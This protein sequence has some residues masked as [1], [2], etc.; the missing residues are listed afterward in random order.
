[1]T[2]KTLPGLPK[3]ELK[4]PPSAPSM[5]DQEPMAIIE[6]TLRASDFILADGAMLVIKP[7]VMAVYRHKSAK[8][9]QGNPV[10]SITGNF[11]VQLAVKGST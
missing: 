2:K 7:N 9:P 11:K 6:E 8:D 3:P 10:Y 5:A 1:M 4:S